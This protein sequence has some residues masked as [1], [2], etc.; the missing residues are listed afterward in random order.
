[1]GKKL[2][3]KLENCLKWIIYKIFRWKLSEST[4]K[5]LLQFVEFGI[6]GLSNTVIG[7][8]IYVVSLF[9]LR[10]IDVFSVADIYIAQ[11]IMFLLSVLWSFFW[12][13]KMVFRVEDGE[14]RNLVFALVKTYVTYAFTT[15]FLSEVLLLVWVDVLGISEFIAPVINLLITVPLNFF[16]QK[17]WA[18]ARR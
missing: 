10:Y 5:G 6:I 13:N 15:L 14:Q 12:N 2:W 1:M 8:L 9:V 18:F 16:I 3:S 7:Y 4:W 17:F 11:F